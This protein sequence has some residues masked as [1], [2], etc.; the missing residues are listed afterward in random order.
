MAGK[1]V[2][3][4]SMRPTAS[5]QLLT[6]YRAPEN[7]HSAP[8]GFRHAEIDESMMINRGTSVGRQAD[9]KLFGIPFD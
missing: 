8:V 4:L 7:R 3:M 1:R 2:C 9:C 5:G 6:A